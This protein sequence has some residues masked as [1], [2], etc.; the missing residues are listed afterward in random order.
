MIN[1]PNAAAGKKFVAAV[2]PMIT[3]AKPWGVK[4]RTCHNIAFTKDG[5]SALGIDVASILSVLQQ[6]N[7]VARG[8]PEAPYPSVP[9]APKPSTLDPK[10]YLVQKG[11]ELF[12]STYERL[13]GGTTSSDVG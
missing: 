12:G 3:T 1:I 5:L 10:N 7:S 8:I 2:T 11:P 9:Y 6:Q 13:V 4:P